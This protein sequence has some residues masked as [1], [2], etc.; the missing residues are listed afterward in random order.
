MYLRI[1][2]TVFVVLIALLCLVYAAQNIANLEACR[3]AFAYVMSNADH[4]IY[5]VSFGPAITNPALIWLALVFVVGGELSAGLL[6]AKGALDMWSA[7]KAP[8]GDF[9][10]AKKYALIGSGLGIVV[11]LGFFSVIGGAFFQMWQ[12]TAGQ[13]SMSDAFR[14]LLACGLVF[15]IVSMPED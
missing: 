4:K 7:R 8:A 2:K 9:R 14:F 6:S 13:A 1:L 15:I 10:N 12:T 11:W 5:P 3:A